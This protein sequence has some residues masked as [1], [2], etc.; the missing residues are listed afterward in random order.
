MGPWYLI[1]SL[2]VANC[3]EGK[4]VRWKTLTFTA[5]LGGTGERTGKPFVLHVGV[6]LTL[7]QPLKE[8]PS[9]WKIPGCKT[10]HAI[11]RCNGEILP[12]KKKKKKEF[13][14]SNYTLASSCSIKQW[15]LP[16]TSF[17]STHNSTWTQT[18]GISHW[19]DWDHLMMG[20]LNF[21]DSFPFLVW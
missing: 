3:T 10:Y 12:Y 18:F 6:I 14:S 20:S 19:G 17:S 7:N 4:C 9:E 1:K 13:V 8:I 5:A 21:D 16:I 15:P 2:K 11:L